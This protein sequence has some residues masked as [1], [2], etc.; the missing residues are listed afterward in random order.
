MNIKI[1][2]RSQRTREA[3]KKTLAQM[4]I[5]Q[6]INDITIKNLVVLAN[7]NRSTFYLHYTDIFDLLQEMEND[8]IS[9]IQKVLDSYPSLSRAQSYSFVTDLISVFEAN[10]DSLKALMGYHGDAFFIQRIILVITYGIMAFPLLEV[11][12]KN[13]IIEDKK[14]DNMMSIKIRN[15]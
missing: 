14:K 9:Q 10:R 1:D 3:L 12:Y 5:K 8:I 11:I 13:I 6:N 4:M 2:K 7:I 15:I